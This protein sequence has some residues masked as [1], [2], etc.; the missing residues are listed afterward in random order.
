MIER[1]IQL[2][3]QLLKNLEEMGNRW[4]FE[5]YIR[6]YFN[7]EKLLPDFEVN[8][9]NTGNISSAYLNGEKVSN[10]RARSLLTSLQMSKFY[11]D[12]ARRKFVLKISTNRL[13]DPETILEQLIATM[14]DAKDNEQTKEYK[15]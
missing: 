3:K 9:Y 2:N 8:F 5:K 11:Y 7:A 10:T 14:L 4:E 15:K 1:K 12:I 6:I 13:L